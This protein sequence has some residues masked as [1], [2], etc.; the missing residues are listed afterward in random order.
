[1]AQCRG[2]LENAAALQP[3]RRI[4]GFVS[5][6]VQSGRPIAV[7][8]QHLPRLPQADVGDSPAIAAGLKGNGACI[9]QPGLTPLQQSEVSGVM[10]HGQPAVAQ[11]AEGPGADRLYALCGASEDRRAIAHFLGAGQIHRGDGAVF[12]TDKEGRP[13][14]REMDGTRAIAARELVGLGGEP[15]LGAALW[16]RQHVLPSP[17]DSPF[18]TRPEDLHGTRS[19]LTTCVAKDDQPSSAMGELY[20]D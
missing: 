12:A 1:M 19:T 5:D 3:G 6:V 14:L 9:L 15:R 11:I 17:I 13:V 10:P 18:Q 8:Y 2:I 20:N 16:I 4:A 7:R